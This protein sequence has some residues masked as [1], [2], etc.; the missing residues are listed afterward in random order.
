[1]PKNSAA[2]KQAARERQAVTGEPYTQ[3][4]Q[5][6]RAERAKLLP[7]PPETNHAK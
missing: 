5:A 3:A 4:L 7:S 6:V 2:D 1:M